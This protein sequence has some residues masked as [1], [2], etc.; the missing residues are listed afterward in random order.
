[1]S[2]KCE[3]NKLAGGSVEEKGD[4]ILEAGR[5]EYRVQDKGYGKQRNQTKEQNEKRNEEKWRNELE[6]FEEND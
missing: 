4:F 6:R 1:M 2:V 5:E 3:R